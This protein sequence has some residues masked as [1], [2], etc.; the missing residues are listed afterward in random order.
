VTRRQ[1]SFHFPTRGGARKGAGRPAAGPR[2]IRHDKRI[3]VIATRPIHVTCR[4][5]PR[6]GNL[7]RD[8]IYAAIREATTVVARHD[9]LRIVHLSIQRSH[10]HLLVEAD[11]GRAL[12]HGMCSF[13]I[14]AARHVNRVIRA[15]G[16]VFERYHA[17]SLGTPREVRNC[18]AYV[19]NNWRH[20]GEHRRA[21]AARWLVDKYSSAIAFDGWSEL[22]RG[23]RFAMPAGH[24]PLTVWSPRIW[25]L[26]TGWSR[27]G[28]VSTREAPGGDDDD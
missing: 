23:E 15:D 4:A 25:L 8:A 28:L 24:A 3:R 2:A 19:L 10:I 12:T 22:G 27:H 1:Q 16:R 26:T 20:H 6:V 5:L 21:R 17:R 9:G 11:S 14:S 13:L 18:L 7:R